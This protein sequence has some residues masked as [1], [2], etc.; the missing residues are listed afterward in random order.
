MFGFS[1]DKNSFTYKQTSIGIPLASGIGGTVEFGNDGLYRHLVDQLAVLVG[2]HWNN[3][4]TAGVFAMYLNTVRS[5][6]YDNVGGR[7]SFL[8]QE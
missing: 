1:T 4:S 7:A 3:S 8:V 6:S 5:T 2:G